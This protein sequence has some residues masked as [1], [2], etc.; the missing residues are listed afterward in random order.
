VS[1][2]DAILPCLDLAQYRRLDE[3]VFPNPERQFLN[4]LIVPNFDPN[5]S[6]ARQ[7]PLLGNPELGLNL[8]QLK[9][10]S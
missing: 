1:D 2:D 6:S 7:N 3:T 9:I 5:M 10:P 8:G 4:L